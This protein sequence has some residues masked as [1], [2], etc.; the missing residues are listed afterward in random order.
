[1]QATGNAATS[2]TDDIKAVEW[3]PLSKA[4]ERLSLPHEQFFLRGVGRLALRRT[5][6]KAGPAV[7]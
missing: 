5:E 3:L 1:M 6:S 2:L 7:F 4:I